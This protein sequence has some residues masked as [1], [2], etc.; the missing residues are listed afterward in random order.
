MLK[1]KLIAHLS[2]IHIGHSPERLQA[3]FLIRK[4]LI[5]LNI[6]YVL[7]TGDVTE[8]GRESEFR[9]FQEVFRDFIAKG[10]MSLVPGNHDRLGD[11]IGREMMNNERILVTKREGITIV[12]VDT[13]GP[14]NKHLILGHGTLKES[15]I[16]NIESKI[17]AAVKKNDFVILGLH[18]HPIPQPEEL[19]LEKVATFFR[20]PIARELF[21]GKTL[22][23]QLHGQCD[24]ILHGHRHV[25]L[26]TKFLHPDKP[27]N[28]HIYNAGSSTELLKFRVFRVVDGKFGGVAEWISCV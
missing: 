11:N 3:A 18:H 21:F 15:V 28:L 13:T 17:A 8:H 10:R 7:V 9:Q 16:A 12:T 24:L 22:I 6:D 2:D 23:E 19:W 27:R 25:D 14:H 5:E 4:K 20:T 1:T 26:E